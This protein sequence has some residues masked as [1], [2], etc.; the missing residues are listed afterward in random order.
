MTDISIDTAFDS[1][2]IEVR[3]IKGASAILAI[4]KDHQSEFAQW[5][6]FRV[7]GSASRELELRIVGLENSAY[8]AGWP[9]Y[10]AC[11]VVRPELQ[12]LRFG[13]P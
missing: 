8:P 9:N 5:F 6:H 12:R 1:G 11:V 10:N 7:S 2:N 13:R 4:R 3:S